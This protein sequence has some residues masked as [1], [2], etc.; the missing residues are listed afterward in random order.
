[1]DFL[2]TDDQT[3]LLAALDNALSQFDELPK[4]Y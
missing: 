3:A 1:M 2:L 4:S